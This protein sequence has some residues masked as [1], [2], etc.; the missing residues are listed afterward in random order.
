MSEQDVMETQILLATKV[1]GPTLR[2]LRDH[3]DAFAQSLVRRSIENVSDLN[4][5]DLRQ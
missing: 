1:I 5:E 2:E 3:F 4:T